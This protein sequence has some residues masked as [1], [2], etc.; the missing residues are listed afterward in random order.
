MFC[1]FPGQSWA[2]F[3][4]PTVRGGLSFMLLFRTSRMFRLIPYGRYDA[5]ALTEGDWGGAGQIRQ[6]DMWQT[7]ANWMLEP[8]RCRS[9]GGLQL[10]ASKCDLDCAA[11]VV[12]SWQRFYMFFCVKLSKIGFLEISHV[13]PSHQAPAYVPHWHVCSTCHSTLHVHDVTC[14][15]LW[16]WRP[17]VFL[18]RPQDNFKLWLKGQKNYVFDKTSGHLLPFFFVGEHDLC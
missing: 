15:Q 10:W 4:I 9:S 13:Q 1:W 5:G 11:V 12:S 18:R 14:Q 7:T 2:F 8:M 16:A 17:W 6:A 3:S